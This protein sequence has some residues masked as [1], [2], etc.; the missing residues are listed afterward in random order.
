[1]GVRDCFFGFIELISDFIKYKCFSWVNIFSLWILKF[2][3]L[4]SEF[5]DGER[6]RKL[7]LFVSN[8]FEIWFL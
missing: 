5:I 4:N 3:M 1:M 8:L 7:K 2:I 6:M